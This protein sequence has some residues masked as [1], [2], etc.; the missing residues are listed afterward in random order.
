MRVHI[1]CGN[2]EL[3]NLLVNIFTSNRYKK[4]KNLPETING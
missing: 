4:I 3:K 1:S 2:C